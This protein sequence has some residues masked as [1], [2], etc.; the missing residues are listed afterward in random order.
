MNKLFAFLGII[1]LFLF[2]QFIVPT[3]TA[4]SDQN[5]TPQ[6]VYCPETGTMVTVCVGHQWHGC[7]SVKGCV[8]SNT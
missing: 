6:T 7:G 5:R 1:L 8:G 3:T 4:Q 2:V